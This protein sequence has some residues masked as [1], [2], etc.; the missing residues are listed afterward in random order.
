MF[1]QTVLSRKPTQ[2]PTPTSPVLAASL[3]AVLIVITIYVASMYISSLNIMQTGS[4]T[5]SFPGS[6]MC[7]SDLLISMCCMNDWI[8]TCLGRYNEEHQLPTARISRLGIVNDQIVRIFGIVNHMV[9]ATCSFLSDEH[10]AFIDNATRWVWLGSNKTVYKT[11]PE[12][13]LRSKA[14]KT[15]A[16]WPKIALLIW[17]INFDYLSWENQ[18]FCWMLSVLQG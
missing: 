2:L 10:Q 7:H 9:S 17:A 14:H 12:L 3:L 4:A 16:P 11:G 6:R 8:A 15:M 5:F 13:D 1:I 18:L